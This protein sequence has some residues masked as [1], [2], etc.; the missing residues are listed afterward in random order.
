VAGAVCWGVRGR[1]SAPAPSP[2]SRQVPPTP[3]PSPPLPLPLSLP[4]ALSASRPRARWAL[5]CL[6]VL[7][8]T[9]GG[10]WPR[11]LRYRRAVG[12]LLALLPRSSPRAHSRAPL[13]GRRFRIPSKY[14]LIEALTRSL[15][16]SKARLQDK[17]R[18]LYIAMPQSALQPETLDPTPESEPVAL[19]WLSRLRLR[20]RHLMPHCPAH[21]P[22]PPLLPS[23]QPSVPPIPSLL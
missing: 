10:C 19:P 2:A 22:A 4:L 3:S 11:A 1:Q 18:K 9:S 13:A 7:F 15:L 14:R 12:A 6:L 5:R 16:G 8:D 20:T 21:P 23:I 17:A